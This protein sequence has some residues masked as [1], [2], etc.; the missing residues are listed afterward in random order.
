MTLRLNEE[1][2]GKLLT[3]H[4]TK[5]IKD[6]YAEFVPTFERLVQQHGKLRVLFD[7][8]D[9]HGWELSA[10]WEDTKFGIKHFADIDRLAMVGAKAWQHGM[11]I[12]CKPFTGAQVRYFV[13]AQTQHQTDATA[14]EN[15]ECIEMDLHDITVLLHKKP[16]AGLDL[17]TA[18]GKQFHAAERLVRLR[19]ARQRPPPRQSRLRRSRRAT[20]QAH[21]GTRAD[22]LATRRCRAAG[23]GPCCPPPAR[24]G[25]RPEPIWLKN[26]VG[27]VDNGQLR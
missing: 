6:D 1:N 22:W 16:D 11:A 25:R 14:D 15:S 18:L 10:A 12:F 5:L 13:L 20:G 24:P 9:F 19:A 8:T 21:C 17:M 3:I 23:G 2:N 7:M 26:P 27:P 4:V